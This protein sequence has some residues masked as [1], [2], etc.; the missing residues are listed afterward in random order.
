MSPYQVAQ[1]RFFVLVVLRIPHDERFELMAVS[2]QTAIV[3]QRAIGQRRL[4]GLLFLG[5]L[6]FLELLFLELFDLLDVAQE[7]RYATDGPQVRP[8]ARGLT[9]FRFLHGLCF[10][11]PSLGE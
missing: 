5:L 11:P 8:L 9:L 7:H 1:H 10:L 4:L 6:L 3:L 2:A